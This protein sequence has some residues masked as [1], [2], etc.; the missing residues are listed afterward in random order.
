MTTRGLDHDLPSSSLLASRKKPFGLSPLPTQA[1]QSRPLGVRSMPMTMLPG[2]TASSYS[3]P[4]LVLTTGGSSARSSRAGPTSWALGAAVG[5]SSKAV[6][7]DE[8]AFHSTVLDSGTTPE[9][10]ERSIPW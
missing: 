3:G 8:R 4:G 10:H 7:D 5:A 9:I 6:S 1:A 2:R